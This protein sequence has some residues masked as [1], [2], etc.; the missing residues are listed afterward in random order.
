MSEIIIPSEAKEKWKSVRKSQWKYAKNTLKSLG[1]DAHNIK[2]IKPY[3]VEGFQSEPGKIFDFFPEPIVQFWLCYDQSKE[4][5]DEIWEEYISVKQSFN[6]DRKLFFGVAHDGE[7]EFLKYGV[8]P[9]IKSREQTY[10][11]FGG[12][13]KQ[14][15]EYFVPATVYTDEEMEVGGRMVRKIPWAN[16]SET[17][18]MLLLSILEPFVLNIGDNQEYVLTK[19][20]PFTPYQWMHSILV[21]TFNYDVEATFNENSEYLA[22]VL[23]ILKSVLDDTLVERFHPN[24]VQSGLKLIEIFEDEGTPAYLR[25]LWLDVR[26]GRYPFQSN[27]IVEWNV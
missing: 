16:P 7:C 22:T 19:C 4:A 1:M 6:S 8:T 18:S 21:S 10:G 5:W 12:L 15:L 20:S 2:R 25:N 14:M 13:E 17:F 9:T 27:D 3:Y 24:H 26:D 11:A 23:L